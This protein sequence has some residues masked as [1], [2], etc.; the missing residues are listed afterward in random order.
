MTALAA[1][2]QEDKTQMTQRPV[3]RSLFRA[4]T[5]TVGTLALSAFLTGTAFAQ[6]AFS[7]AILVNDAAITYFE[8]DQRA[9]LLAIMNAPGNPEEL[10]REQ[11]IEDRL[12]AQAARQIGIEPSEEG[13]QSGIEN[14]AARVNMN[15]EDLIKALSGEG[16]EEETLRDFL[17]S[18]ITWG[19]VVQ[20]RFGRNAEIS[21]DEI[22]RAIAQNSGAGGVRVLLSEIIIPVTPQNARQVNSLAAQISEISSFEEFEAA[23]RT[24]SAAGT[25]EDGGRVDWMNVTKLPPALRPVLS[26]MRPGDVSPPLQLPNAV[27]IFQMRSVAETGRAAPNYAAIDYITYLLPGG[28]TEENLQ[29]AARIRATVDRC[30]DLFGVAFGKPEELLT[31]ENKAP[32]EIPKDIGLELAKLDDNEISTNLTTANGQS[33]I[34]LMLCGRTATL[35][36]EISREDVAQSLRNTR[37]ES[38]A[39]SYLS[40]LRAQA[41]ISQK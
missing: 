21:E 36:E 14:F 13:I 29:E 30:D 40:Q 2:L 19:A 39:N 6:N 12:K 24:Y 1:D 11:L 18:Q 28:R 26:A 22:D 34:V 33:M 7:P 41:R 20:T 3:I 37:L 25:K 16:V 23:A 15:P 27:A 4:L 35:D 8:L 9:R 31:R 17:A 10:A 32:N 38:Y 5:G